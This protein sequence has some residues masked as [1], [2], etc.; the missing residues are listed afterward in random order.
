MMNR[1]EI[2]VPTKYIEVLKLFAAKNDIRYYLNGICFEFGCGKETLMLA[3]NGHK[4][5]IFRLKEKFECETRQQYIVP[6][7]FLNAL[8]LSKTLIDAPFTFFT[9]NKTQKITALDK[10][11]FY[12]T[13]NAIDGCFPNYYRLAVEKTNGEAGWFQPQ[14]LMDLSKAAK[15]LHNDPLKF[16]VGDNSGGCCPISLQDENF[17]GVLLP[18]SKTLSVEKPKATAQWFYDMCQ[19]DKP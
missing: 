15:I 19:K 17:T 8:K 1:Y 13:C 18:L 11:G 3:T 7:K 16:S 10:E 2:E 4:F 5:G 12:I 14:Y 6:L 9:E